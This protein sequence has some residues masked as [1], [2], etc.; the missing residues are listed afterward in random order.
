MEELTQ[1]IF[2]GFVQLVVKYLSPALANGTVRGFNKIES[3]FE[4]IVEKEPS[5][6]KNIILLIT[7]LPNNITNEMGLDLYRLTLF[8]DKNKYENIKEFVK[9]F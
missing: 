2:K 4:K 8:L 6:R 3:L 5:L 1:T 9:D 7:S